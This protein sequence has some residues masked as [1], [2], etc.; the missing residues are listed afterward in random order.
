MFKTVVSY[1]FKNGISRSWSSPVIACYNP[2]EIIHQRLVVPLLNRG[3]HDIHCR[4]HPNSMRQVQKTMDFLV[5]LPWITHLPWWKTKSTQSLPLHSPTLIHSAICWD[6]VLNLQAFTDHISTLPAGK[7][8]FAQVTLGQRMIENSTLLCTYML[9]K[10][11]TS[12]TGKVRP[13]E[14]D[15]SY[16][17]HHSKWPKTTW[18]PCKFSRWNRMIPLLNH[19]SST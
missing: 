14:D 6:D 4:N 8:L 12:P 17:H 19:R 3:T 15:S 5:E 16:I 2:T 9:T 13:F 11:S 7:I 1:W 10:Y 18:G